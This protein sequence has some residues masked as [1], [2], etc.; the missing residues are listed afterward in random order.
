MARLN[1]IIFLCAFLMTTP[2]FADYYA[3]IG[4]GWNTIDETFDSNLYTNEN[5]SGQDRYETSANRLAPVVQVGYQSPLC[6]DWIIGILGQWKYLNYKTPN[7]NSSRGQILP[8]ATFS[9]IN[10]F[11][12]DIHRDF[13]S[14]TCLRNEV[15]LL[16][17]V[18]KQIM[19]GYGYLGMGPVLFTASNSV[20]VTSV[21]TPNG[22]G[23]HLISTSATR[24][25]TVW[26]GAVQV[27]YQ[28]CLS[29]NSFINIGYTYVQTGKQHFKNSVNAAILNGGSVPGPTTLF[30]KRSVRFSVQEL[31]LSMNLLF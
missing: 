21:H 24:H 10:I 26:G 11:G 15:K 14:K 29:S 4:F 9:S 27:G 6:N 13:T 12:G 31:M 22:V 3:G 23:D 20:Y 1:K 19:N 5:R 17:L 2:L 25:K 7:V 30:L 28:Y 8:N 16:G 18:E